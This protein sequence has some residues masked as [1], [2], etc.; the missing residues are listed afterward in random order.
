M[1]MQRFP[2]PK[3]LDCLRLNQRNVENYQFNGILQ[4]AGWQAFA[5]E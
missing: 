2:C 1:R 3:I 4:D 5:G